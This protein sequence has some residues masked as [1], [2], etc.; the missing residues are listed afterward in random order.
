MKKVRIIISG[1]VQGVGFRYWLYKKATERKI[2][3]WVKN[4]IMNKVEAVL[5]GNTKDIDYIPIKDC[6]TIALLIKEFDTFRR[7]KIKDVEYDSMPLGDVDDEIEIECV[8]IRRKDFARYTW[9]SLCDDSGNKITWFSE[10]TEVAD[11]G[12]RLNISA[13]VSDIRHYKKVCETVI[14]KV[15]INSYV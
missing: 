10:T 13:V 4:I 1:K 12:D 5:V 9:F 8:V 6:P 11:I 3:G 14:K 7:S 2:Y 15:K